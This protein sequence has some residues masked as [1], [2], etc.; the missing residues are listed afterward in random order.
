MVKGFR[1]G[2][3]LLYVFSEKCL[4]RFK[5]NRNGAKIFVC[6][7]T[8]LSK[9]TKRGPSRKEDR[10][11]CN[12]TVR[13]NADGS[14]TFVHTP[15]TQHNDHEAIMR[16]M[17]KMNTIKQNCKVLKDKF[18]EDSHKIPLRNIYQREIAK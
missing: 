2:S 10:C 3:E 6:Y 15:H 11:E 7:Q 17:S 9:P 8:I 4:Y 13:L 1:E 12:A 16:D 14:C 5:R 18:A